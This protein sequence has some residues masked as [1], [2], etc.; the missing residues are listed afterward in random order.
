[1]I[2]IYNPMKNFT[3]LLFFFLMTLMLPCSNIS[4]QSETCADFNFDVEADGVYCGDS[5]G[6]IKISNINN[7]KSGSYVIAWSGEDN[8]V[9]ETTNSFLP[10]YNIENLR[11]GTYTIKVRN[12]K[13]NCTAT[14]TITLVGNA[15]PEGL[16]VVGNSIQCNGF[17]NIS[18]HLPNDKPP[19][20]IGLRGPVSGTYLANSNS[21]KLHNLP[22]GDYEIDFIKDGCLATTSATVT[23]D[24]SLPNL[25]VEAVTGGCQISTGAVLV[26]ATGGKG[27]YTLSWKGPTTGEVVISENLELSGFQTGTYQFTLED[28]TGCKSIRTLS[29]NRTGLS[30]ELAASQAICDKNG[31]IRV[32]ISAGTAPYTIEYSTDGATEG[33]V[34]VEG[35]SA[36]LSVPAG[37]YTVSVTD[38]NGCTIFANATVDLKAS[39]LYASA[40]AMNTTCGEDNGRLKVLA[41]GGK[42]PYTISYDGP[43]SGSRKVNGWTTFGNLPAGSY[44]TTIQDAEGC[45]IS[46]SAAIKIG[47]HTPTSSAYTFSA[48][49]TDVFFFNN[50]TTGSSEW[51]FGDGNSSDRTNPSHG[52]RNPGTYEVCL[53]TTD[54]CGS[55]TV[56][57][58][59]QLVALRDVSRENFNLGSDTQLITTG[60]EENG[61]G[62]H[63]Q[64]NFPNPF[65]N[66]TE[67]IFELPEALLTTIMIHDHS[68]KTVKT[69][70]A[71]YEKGLNRFTFNQNSL[72]SGVYFYT[73][74]AGAFSLTKSMVI[75]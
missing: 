56:C 13:N 66:S 35:S 75:D 17:G 10:F 28:G 37:N 22:A 3:P 27:G 64:Q 1:M 4:A 6:A 2:K 12:F 72:S 54:E 18:I 67:I 65:S 33:I 11:P 52:Y 61:E 15:L 47:D 70:T 40:Q 49:G 30:A 44:T 14:E 42:K 43:T 31:A 8:D 16:S 29:I 69:V 5:R 21:F 19:F 45:T 7:G 9:S 41:T 51:T 34:I 32:D 36:S 73:I 25:S 62:L 74:K 38:A 50:S 24:N 39:N 23:T 55:S 46:Q 60:N 63:I 57:Q 68:G 20:Y 48:N 58:T 59:I 26:N 71:N 53:T